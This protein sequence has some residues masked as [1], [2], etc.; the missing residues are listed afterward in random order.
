M[1]MDPTLGSRALRSPSFWQANSTHSITPPAQTTI[2]CF[3]PCLPFEEEKPQT[4]SVPPL[5]AW[6]QAEIT[7]EGPPG[8]T[9]LASLRFAASAGLFNN[10]AA[11]PHQ[12]SLSRQSHRIS[13]LL[14]LLAAGRSVH[15]RALETSMERL[16]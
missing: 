8:P 10:S 7:G 11:W 12:P 1:T 2:F 13:V 6:T 9:P 16:I 3:F 4:L 5:E 14:I 15:K